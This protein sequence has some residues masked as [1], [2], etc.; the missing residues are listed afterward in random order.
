MGD[1]LGGRPSSSECYD[2]DRKVNYQ[3]MESDH[4][5]LAGIARVEKAMSKGLQVAIMCSEL[6]PE[7]CHRTKLIGK[8]LGDR[9]HVVRHL[10]ADGTVIDQDKVLRRITGGQ[11]DFFGDPAVIRSRGAYKAR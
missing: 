3:K 4:Q 10:D 5:F 7:E 9:G 6:R 1:Q 11:S 8:V 2:S